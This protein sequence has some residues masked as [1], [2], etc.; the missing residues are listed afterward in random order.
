[1]FKQALTLKYATWSS[2]PAWYALFQGIAACETHLLFERRFEKCLFWAHPGPG[3]V[4]GD[5]GDAAGAQLA[6][7][8]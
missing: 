6:I 8:G 2:L 4:P 5:F 3:P 7:S 1:M